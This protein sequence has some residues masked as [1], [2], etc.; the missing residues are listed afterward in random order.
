VLLRVRGVTGWAYLSVRRSVTK[1]FRYA[2]WL[3][4]NV[5]IRFRYK[6]AGFGPTKH[7]GKRW[8]FILE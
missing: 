3:C 1:E 8:R 7:P 4:K 2:F 5:A 6:R